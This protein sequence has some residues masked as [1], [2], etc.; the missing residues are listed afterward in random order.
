MGWWKSEHG[1]IGDWPSDIMAKA[2]N[3]LEDVYMRECGRLPT[4]GEIADLIEFC[5]MGVLKP[6][7]G[8]PNYSFTDLNDDK[9]PRA[10][11]RGLQGAL[12]EAPPK[13]KLANIDPAT[14]EH[15]SLND[16]DQVMRDQL[17][18]AKNKEKMGF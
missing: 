1:A 13:G 4:Q 16:I 8:D 3:L 5:S 15:Y 7:C 6:Q 2:F 11:E 18:E 10:V 17:K 12:R 14:G 9:T